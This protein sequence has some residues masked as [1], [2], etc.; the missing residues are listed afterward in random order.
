MKRLLREWN[1]DNFWVYILSFS[2]ITLFIVLILGTYL[3]VYYYKTIYRDF[4]DSNEE[5][6]SAVETQHESDMLMLNDI[7]TQL[8]L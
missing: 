4:M 2:A 3:Y 1:K 7:M 8:S 5:Y 6:L